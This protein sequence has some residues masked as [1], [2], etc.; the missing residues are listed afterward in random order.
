MVVL[1]ESLLVFWVG[2]ERAIDDLLL[3]EVHWVLSRLDSDGTFESSRGGE[4]PTG[5]ALSLVLNIHNLSI[6]SPID[7]GGSV[8]LSEQTRISCSVESADST[9]SIKTSATA[10]VMGFF[11]H[12]E[13]VDGIGFRS[14]CVETEKAQVLIRGEI[15]SPVV[16]EDK[17]IGVILVTLSVL[18]VDGIVVLLIDLKSFIVFLHR[19]VTLVVAALE[20]DE[21]CVTNK[22]FSHS[23][24]CKGCNSE[25]LFHF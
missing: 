17:A 8:S 21:V 12:F 16:G 11:T 24:S 25:S 15:G 7:I 18:F 2:G 13:A 23:E 9:E 14:F 6:V 20:L 5:T 1:V 4:G 3:G 22:V 10:I 19:F